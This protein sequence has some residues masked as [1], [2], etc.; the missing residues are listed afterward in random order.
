MTSLLATFPGA[1]V[2]SVVGLDRHGALGA[3]AFQKQLQPEGSARYREMR[4]PKLGMIGITAKNLLTRA[5]WAFEES[6]V[7]S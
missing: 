2:V 1:R 5:S 7:F 3:F 6:N 4:T